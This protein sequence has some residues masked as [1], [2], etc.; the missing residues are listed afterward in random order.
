MIAWVRP[1]V[2]VG[3]PRRTDV[4]A[5]PVDPDSAVVAIGLGSE[6][7]RGF[8]FENGHGVAGARAFGESVGHAGCLRAV[9]TRL[10]PLA[11][12]PAAAES[13]HPESAGKSRS[14]RAERSWVRFETDFAVLRISEA[15]PGR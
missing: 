6:M 14:G 13:V 12:G 9:G 15:G 1:R 4:V 2:T 7:R 11:G 3:R 5:S 8:G 10:V